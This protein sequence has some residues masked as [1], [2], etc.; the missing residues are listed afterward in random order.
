MTD[1]DW[2][3]R[4]A[5]GERIVVRFSG[6]VE[7]VGDSS[8]ESDTPLISRADGQ[9]GEPVA[10][11]PGL[12][13]GE[14]FNLF[15]D[16]RLRPG[17]HSVELQIDDSVS[18][19]ALNLL[20][21]DLVIIPVQ[22]QI[23]SEGRVDVSVRVENVGTVASQS[24][25]IF[26]NSQVVE[27]IQP[28]AVG[29]GK[30]VTLSLALP[31][32]A[33]TISIAVVKDERE[34]NSADNSVD[35][36]VEIDYVSLLLRAT[37]VTLGDFIRGGNANVAINFNVTNVGVAASDAFL[38]AAACP[39]VLE[40][41]CVGEQVVP[42]LAPGQ[43]Y[44]GMIEAVVPQGINGFTLFAGAD[45][46]GFLWGDS[47]VVDVEI[48]VPD[49]PP[50]AP[51]FTVDAE[52]T[53]YYSN[54]DA[55]VN[56]TSTLRNDGSQEL[57]DMFTIAASCLQEG[58]VVEECA[59]ISTLQLEDGYGP[60]SAII[61]L[62]VPVGEV[63]LL[64]GTGEVHQSGID[65]SRTVPIDVP[66]RI[67]GIDRKVWDCF[68]DTR[69]SDTHRR[70]SCS[71]RDQDTVEKWPNGGIVKF[72]I[73][74]QSAYV[75][76]FQDTVAEILPDINLTYEFV[77][78]ADEASVEVFVGLSELDARSL[79]FQDCDG[80]WGCS[81]YATDDSGNVTTA[82]IAVLQ[83]E[84]DAVRK[85]GIVNETIQ[86]AMLHHLLSAIVPLGM[87]DVA[88]SVM[89][90]DAGTR[91]PA[92]SES[93]RQLLRIYGSPLVNA[94]DTATDIEP[95][96]VFD[97]DLIDAPPATELT[98][99]DIVE[100]ARLKLHEDGTALFR[101]EGEWA[102]GTC[103]GGFGPAQVTVSDIGSNQSLSHRLESTNRQM[104]AFFETDGGRVEYWLHGLRWDT[105]R[106]I[107]DE[108]DLP[109]RGISW[110]PVFSDP[111]VM[112]A[113]ILWFASDDYTELLRT[114]KTA[115]YQFDLSRPFVSLTW[116]DDVD[117]DITL[118]ID[119]ATYEIEAFEMDWSFD[120][121]GLQCNSYSVEAQLVEYG[122]TINIPVEVRDEARYL[123]R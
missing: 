99:S 37:S 113:S 1:L 71:G 58:D 40:S 60:A 23:V 106:D 28:L 41:S 72:W 86:F 78:T 49:Q 16:L 104:Y 118:T 51:Q 11:I 102:G 59:G 25:E 66:K 110:S 116:T 9:K 101:M 111:M 90:V 115:T 36:S 81:S 119:L 122:G 68:A 91:M 67:V 65:L 54:G 5:E 94:G 33:Q 97:E 8:R 80:Y 30:A 29:E 105:V 70:G 120:V 55:Q 75:E 13:P 88:D 64:I 121:R 89:S 83:V 14:T 17:E 56:V 24:A 73:D 47:N 98:A 109:K 50:F 10:E 74:G 87:R 44:E 79:G 12:D 69:Y 103:I 112:L 100:Q 6:S 39:S 22:Y 117:V 31:V 4:G 21:S 77:D 15:F 62:R 57:R 46:D 95:L 82:E 7:N 3:I 53:G 84:S 38:V 63:E 114:D 108:Q 48:D 52:V 35:V 32:G 43:T 61:S 85:L 34:V 76:Q 93:D 26:A 92:L 19:V 107:T 96:V 2:E 27:T 18:L 123:E 20:A 42:P 45:D